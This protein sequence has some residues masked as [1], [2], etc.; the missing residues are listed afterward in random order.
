[1]ACFGCIAL[2]ATTAWAQ[3]APS[4]T[5]VDLDAVTRND[6]SIK[7]LPLN[8]LGDQVAIW[9]S[10][11]H[12]KQS[13]GNW[14]LPLGLATGT[15]IATDRWVPR[16]LSLSP[17]TQSSFG[18]LSNAG[19]SGFLAVTGGTY[20][21]GKF[22]HDER[23]QNAGLLAGEAMIDALATGQLLKYSFSRERPGQGS[24]R[25]KFWSGGNGFPSDHAMLSWASASALTQAYP[26]WGT[27][28]LL[29]GGATAVSVS[30]VLANQH[31]PSD[32]LIGSTL[33]YLIGK[34]VYRRHTVER[35]IREQYGTFK[36]PPDEE[37]Q[38]RSS[39]ASVYVPLDSWVYAAFDRLIALGYVR[40]SIV[41]LRPWTRSEC[42]RLIDSI[43]DTDDAASRENPAFIQSL[44]DAL[45]SEFAEPEQSE[46]HQ[47]SGEIE[48]VYFRATGVSG[49]PL[50]D[51]FN[52]GST[53]VNDFGRPFQEGFDGIAGASARAEYGPLAFYLRL[54]YQHV[55]GAPPLPEAARIAI[56]HGVD[57]NLPPAPAVPQPQIDRLRL[58]D[59][60]VSWS[61]N[62]VQVSFGKQS[63]WWGPGQNGAMLI[64]DNAEPINMIRID[65]VQPFTLPGI[66]KYLGP[67]RMQV[68]MGR[69]AG[70]NFI[71]LG[72][73]PIGTYVQPLSDQPYVTGQK[74]SLKPTPNLEIGISRTS[75]FGGPAFPVTPGRL[76][77][78]L[79]SLS[80]SNTSGNDPGDRRTGFDFSYRIPGLRNWLT[81]YADAM[82]EDEINP[83]AY[84]R[85]SAMNPGIYLSHLPKLPHVDFRAE[86]AYTDLPG[87]IQSDYFYWNVRY[88]NGYTNNGNLIG[89]WVGRQ[90]KA[91]QLTSNYWLSGK[92]K[93]QVSYRKLEVSPDTGHGGNQQAFKGS[94][95][96]AMSSSLRASGWVQYERWNFPVLAPGPRSN[97]SV[98][99]QV[100][101]TPKWRFHD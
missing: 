57:P 48:S 17:G 93:I 67:M 74:L 84:P 22:R 5:A 90:G 2:L 70:Q 16:T 49:K 96:T 94:I 24:T 69:L 101:Y 88:I 99:V 64:S 8:L 35:E 95:D 46:A 86:A 9:E 30:R 26:G 79:F 15:M 75:V 56:A 21:L 33:G 76:G 13:D 19:I 32:V 52:F 10:P 44:I 39:R 71:D 98:G 87:L 53:F 78:V 11:R 66:L 4:Q 62:K 89:D 1:M 80:T 45:Q 73:T 92:D 81:L 12:L 65:Q 31:S 37:P 43:D 83:I 68:F 58:L 54:E 51:D 38:R 42:K 25:D 85:R 61:F 28:L 50:T 29:Y 47:F 14:L 63:L 100:S 55:P 36:Q 27:K 77:T 3:Q 41:G 82:A 97:I 59:S 18:T 40:S 34:K 7:R 20:L 91:L 6:V 72:G 60:Y 23:Q